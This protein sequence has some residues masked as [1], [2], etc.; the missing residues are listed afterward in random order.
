LRNF[1]WNLKSS[2][3]QIQ[4]MKW[5]LNTIQD[6]EQQALVQKEALPLPISFDPAFNLVRVCDAYDS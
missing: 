1:K 4:P 2:I 3:Q 5:K 6:S